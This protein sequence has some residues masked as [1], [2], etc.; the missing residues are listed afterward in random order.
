MNIFYKV[1]TGFAR[2][3]FLSIPENELAKAIYAHLF[4]TIF[5]HSKGTLSGKLIQRID[6]D[7]HRALGLNFDYELKGEDM[8]SLPTGFKHNAITAIGEAENKVKE[9]KTLGSSRLGLSTATLDN[10]KERE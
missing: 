7:Y 4:G 8:R 10:K 9:T 5:V 3:E 6:P 2:D 1:K